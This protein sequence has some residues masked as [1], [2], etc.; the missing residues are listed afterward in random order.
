MIY[1]L[2]FGFFTTSEYP[3]AL[4]LCRESRNAVLP[5]YPLC[6][7]TI[8]H[9]AKTRFNF[10]LDTLYMDN[11]FEEEIPHLFAAMGEKEIKGLKYVAVD[12]YFNGADIAGDVDSEFVVAMRRAMRALEGLVELQIVFDITV[13]SDSGRLFGCGREDHPME[14]HEK[15]P[16]E[17]SNPKFGIHEPSLHSDE[18]DLWKVKKVSPMYGWRRCPSGFDENIFERQ[19]PT[20][21]G[22][23]D[24]LLNILGHVGEDTSDTSSSESE[25]D[26]DMTS[27]SD[28]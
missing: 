2:P 14:V 17:L 12:S 16:K 26:D 4:G 21:G 10:D 22:M 11:A 18:Y 23:G 13:L 1:D 20:V 6:F 27:E 5:Y 24:S 9:P 19:R 15:L 25:S 28:V 3:V 8:F 7:G